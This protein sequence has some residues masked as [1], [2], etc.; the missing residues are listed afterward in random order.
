MKYKDK[1][2]GIS[3]Q[4]VNV[5]NE[6]YHSNLKPMYGGKVKNSEEKAADKEYIE[7]AL[8]TYGNDTVL[9][10]QEAAERGWYYFYHNIIDTAI[11]RFNQ[12]WLIDSTYPE[13]YFGFA[14]IKDYQGLTN[15]SEYFFEL[16]Y[17][18]D[19]TDSLSAQILSR[20]ANI[21]EQQKDT[22]AAI[23][24][25]KR[26]FNKYSNNGIASANVGYYYSTIHKPD[27]ALK[28]YN[29]TI[30]I[31]PELENTYLNRGWLYYIDGRYNEAIAD[32]TTIIKMNKQ[33]IRAYVNRGNVLMDKGEFQ[34][35]IKD[36]NR[37]I[38]LDTKHP[39][40]H[41][42][43]AEC[44]HQLNQDSNACEEIK[45]GIEKGGQYAAKMKEYNCK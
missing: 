42:A 27:S 38:E 5:W 17:K 20:I 4:N 33:S 29:I 44:F 18:H 12:S 41:F 45:I 24:A 19:E 11:F 6:G 39:N 23:I 22:L 36:I 1:P 15:E 31:S 37:C 40:F 14:A 32:Y 2:Q 8:E 28:Y 7:F 9:A 10:A 16:A 25:Y 35:A 3:D 43:K 26:A 13:S 30:K 34:Q 21:K